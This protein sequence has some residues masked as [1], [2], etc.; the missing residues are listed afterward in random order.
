MR[1]ARLAQLETVAGDAVLSA[2]AKILQE[3]KDDKSGE[4]DLDY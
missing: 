4:W 3:F 2:C 1:E